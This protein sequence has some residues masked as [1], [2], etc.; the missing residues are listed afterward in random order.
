[1][2]TTKIL[3]SIFILA[4][5]TFLTFGCKKDTN[6]PPKANA[7]ITPSTG[8]INT[9]F[10]V[11]VSGSVDDEDPSEL[12]TYRYD[13][14]NDGTYDTATTNDTCWMPALKEEGDYVLKIEV[15]D[16]NGDTDVTT[17]NYGVSNSTGLIPAQFLFSY[18]TSINYES[19]NTGR[20]GR[21]IFN[22]LDIVTDHFRLIRTY[23]DAYNSPPTIDGT[24]DSV[25]KYVVANSEK[26]ISWYL[27]HLKALLP[28]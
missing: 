14:N 18:H 4:L 8:S 2:K 25:I 5:F 21:N 17:I 3:S 27:V 20:S 13:Y 10:M 11:D 7:I 1:M 9:V 6:T 24:Q 28:Y 19:W 23:H 16:S 12:L 15:T 26:E 22:D